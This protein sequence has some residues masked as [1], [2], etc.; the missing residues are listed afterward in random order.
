MYVGRKV[1]EDADGWRGDTRGLKQELLQR[2]RPG[3]EQKIAGDWG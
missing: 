2:R 3:A 1:T